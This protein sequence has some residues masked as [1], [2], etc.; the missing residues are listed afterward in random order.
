MFLGNSLSVKYRCQGLPRTSFLGISQYKTK[1]RV[2]YWCPVCSELTRKLEIQKPGL[3]VKPVFYQRRAQ[4]ESVHQ[5]TC[6]IYFP[7]LSRKRYK[8]PQELQG[9]EY[10][11]HFQLLALGYDSDL[12]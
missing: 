11:P 9:P 4:I 6:V 7:V 2:I 10:M 5:C 1:S 8:K 3:R 12:E